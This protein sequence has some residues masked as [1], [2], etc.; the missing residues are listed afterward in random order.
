M[1]SITFTDLTGEATLS[2]GF[3]APL[4]RFSNWTPDA[5]PVGP[6]HEGLGT[7]ATF[8]WTHRTDYVVGLEIDKMPASSLPTAQRLKLHLLTGGTCTVT[9]NDTAGN[10]YTCMLAPGSTP[11]IKFTDRRRLRYTF[12]VHLKNSAAAPLECT[13]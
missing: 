5:I 4:D 11:E 1:A 10:T 7:G 9:T 13:Y 8:M 6:R 2:N 3:S 12:G